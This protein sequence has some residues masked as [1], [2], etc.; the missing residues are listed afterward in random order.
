MVIRGQAEAGKRWI[1]A[2]LSALAAVQPVALAEITWHVDHHSMYWVT[3]H[4]A[5][6]SGSEG[7]REHDLEELPTDIRLQA[8]VEQR[9]AAL[10]LRLRR[11]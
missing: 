10:V 7:F 3:V 9:L 6:A 1:N 5:D 2:R 8:Q 11:A 4:K